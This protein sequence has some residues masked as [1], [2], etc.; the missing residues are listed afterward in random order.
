MMLKSKMPKIRAETGLNS[1]NFLDE[2]HPFKLTG[3][4]CVE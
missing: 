2:S 3:F 1:L 4:V